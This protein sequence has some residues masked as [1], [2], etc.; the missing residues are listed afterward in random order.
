VGRARKAF[1]DR[2]L[3]VKLTPNTADIARVARAAEQGGA[4]GITA[5]NTVLG[6]D[7]D[8]STG[9]PVFARVRAGYSGP[10]I[11]PIALEKVWEVSEA[12]DIPVIGVGGIASVE[13]AR[14]F[15]LAGASA[16]QVGTAFFVDPN[17]PV[18]IAEAL[19]A[20]PEWIRPAPWK[21]EGREG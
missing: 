17:L 14:K 11:L 12:V 3:W 5:I 2:S 6:A 1:P 21:E 15:F 20:N 18:R 4:D 10:G 7:F 9:R 16:I 13:D 19:E 8:L